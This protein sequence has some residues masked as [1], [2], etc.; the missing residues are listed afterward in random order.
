MNVHIYI[1]MYTYIYIYIHMGLLKAPFACLF[2]RKP[3][4]KPHVS[5]SLCFDTYHVYVAD[6]LRAREQSAIISPQVSR[7][8]QHTQYV[9]MG[10]TLCG[11]FA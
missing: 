7:L 10:R 9:S 5:G 6:A 3:E 1:Y 4:G 11:M 2:Y 8:V